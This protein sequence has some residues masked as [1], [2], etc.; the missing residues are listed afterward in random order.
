MRNEFYQLILIGGEE[1]IMDY[2]ARANALVMKLEQHEGGY[3][4]RE[5]ISY[6]KLSTDGLSIERRTFSMLT[7]VKFDDLGEDLARI[8]EN[9]AKEDTGGTR[10][11]VANLRSQVGMQEGRGGGNREDEGSRG[12]H[13]KRDKSRHHHLHLQLVQQLKQQQYQ[14]QT[15]TQRQQQ[16]QQP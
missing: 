5:K 12:G 4:R 15:Q 9:T 14:Q 2:I 11:L 10:A 16:Y 1:S 6:P 8:D 13:C 3:Q 7:G